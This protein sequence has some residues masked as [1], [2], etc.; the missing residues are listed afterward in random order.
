NMSVDLSYGDVK[1][2]DVNQGLT[3]NFDSITPQNAFIQGNPALIAAQQANALGPPG[4]AP[5]FFDKDWTSQIDAHSEFDTNVKREAIGFDG[6]FGSSS[7]SWDGYYQYGLTHREQ[8]VNDNRHL[9]AY[10]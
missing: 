9:N 1:T 4:L 10:N 7:W 2:V 5:P 3:A 8:I 6:K